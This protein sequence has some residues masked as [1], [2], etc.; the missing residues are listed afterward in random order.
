[1]FDQK[2]LLLFATVSLIF[3]VAS[4]ITAQDTIA[5]KATYLND[6]TAQLKLKWPG[7]RLV[8]VVCH[9][10]S[11]PAGYFATPIV[12]TFNAYPHLLHKGLKEQFP[13][14]VTNV[15]VT[16][17]GGEN[18][19]SGAQRFD[20]DVLSHHPDMLTIDYSLNDR[21]LGVE[22]ARK[23]WSSMIDKALAAK[24]K[25]ILLTPTPDKA[26]KLDD[27]SDPLNQQAQMVRELAAKYNVGLVDSLAAFKQAIK[28][29][30]KLDDL[31]S[32]GNHP[33]RK[34]HDLVAAELLQW[35]PK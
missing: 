5:D 8:N 13:F 14:A 4:K 34:G 31:M 20:R 6:I 10:H 23:A 25:V 15:I 3:S 30:V 33:N 21:G 1:M 18:S 35:F 11:V 29:G 24:I 22:K 2:L 9:G 28:S 17:I 16:A 19:E 12:D 7:N 32:Q 26:S 27:P